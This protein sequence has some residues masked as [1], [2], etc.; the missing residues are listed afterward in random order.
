[1]RRHQRPGRKRRQK[2]VNPTG[3]KLVG[4]TQAPQ[5][6]PAYQEFVK[7]EAQRIVAEGSR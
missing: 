3:L 5:A 2:R 6:K 7:A 1:M 4:G